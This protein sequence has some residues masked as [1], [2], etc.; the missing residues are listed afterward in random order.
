MRIGFR[1]AHRVDPFDGGPHFTARMDEISLVQ[2]TT[3]RRLV[4][5][6]SPTDATV[7]GLCAREFA[8]PPHFRAVPCGMVLQGKDGVRL[9]LGA[10]EHLG[11]CE[12]DPVSCLP[13]R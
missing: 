6:V 10:I 2:E 9:P 8:G 7:T 11:L 4:G 12:G 5:A 1:Y 3:V 13:I